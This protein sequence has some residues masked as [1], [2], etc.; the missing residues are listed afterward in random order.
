MACDLFGERW[1]ALLA[2]RI[3]DRFQTPDTRHLTPAQSRSLVEELLQRL[4][5]RV[6]ADRHQPPIY[7]AEIE[8]EKVA[9]RSRYF[10]AEGRNSKIE[11]RNS[12]EAAH[13]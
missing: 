9:L 7:R 10:G 5:V 4:A 2:A 11:N 12:E 3:A 13:D 1:Q 6:I 8:A